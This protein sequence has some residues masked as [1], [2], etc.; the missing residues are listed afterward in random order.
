MITAQPA[1]ELRGRG[2]PADPIFVVDPG[3][4]CGIA[5]WRPGHE[6]TVSTVPLAELPYELDAEA[7]RN[8]LS[9]IVVENF[10]LDSR[11]A[12]SQAGSDMP[13]PQGIGM[14][15]AVSALSGT[16]L[17]LSPR[18]CK[19]AGKAYIEAGHI[20]GGAEVRAA[21]RNEHERDVVDILAYTLREL[22]RKP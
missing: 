13:A 18:G 3:L 2:L 6:I 22:Q 21:C 9:F 8:C 10:H 11:S 5:V 15:R 12:R 20:P 17:F 14:C 4:T 16:P 19:S 1:I 7:H